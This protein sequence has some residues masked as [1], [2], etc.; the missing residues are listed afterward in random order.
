[1]ATIGA[2][3]TVLSLGASG[4]RATTTTRVVQ[5][6]GYDDPAT[7]GQTGTTGATRAAAI[8]TCDR[9]GAFAHGSSGEPLRF[10]AEDAAGIVASDGTRIT[11]FTGHGVD[12]V[13]GDG[14]K[15]AGVKP[16]ALLDA[17]KNPTKVT[18]GVDRLGRP[19][20]I[21]TGSD[22]RVVVN[23]QTGRIVSVNPL[24]GAGANR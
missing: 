18:E 8:C 6:Y 7:L 14:A 4:A 3:V 15:R 20:K 13:R 19:Y 5:N 16:Q 22:A 10:A 24:S 11:G 21:Y 1:M 2:F 23:P 9:L 12:R 17:I